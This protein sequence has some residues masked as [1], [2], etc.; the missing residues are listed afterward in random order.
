MSTNEDGSGIGN[1]VRIGDVVAWT[2]QAG[3]NYKTKT[4]TIVEVVP[5]NSFATM[6]NNRASRRGHESYIV[7]VKGRR[8]GLYWPHA[9]QLRLSALDI[10]S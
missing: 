7:R 6:G 9:C 3:G 8:G 2:S 1:V 10:L 4:G 5:A